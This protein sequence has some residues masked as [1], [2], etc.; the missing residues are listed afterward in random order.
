MNRL[1]SSSTKTSNHDHA[2]MC[3]SRL[4]SSSDFASKMR[5]IGTDRAS[6]ANLR[7]FLRHCMPEWLTLMASPEQNSALSLNFFGRRAS[8]CA[9]PAYIHFGRIFVDPPS[10]TQTLISWWP[11]RCRI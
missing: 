9:E 11:R 5:W 2:R 6:P 1:R 8:Q 7:P 10:S 3:I 4:R